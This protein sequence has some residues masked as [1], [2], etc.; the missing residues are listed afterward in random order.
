[1]RM[2]D[3]T[4]S[5]VITT[6]SGELMAREFI[7]PHNRQTYVEGREGSNF[8]LRLT[9]NTPN[10]V[11]AVPSVDGL[12]VLDGMA[13][14]RDSGGFVLEGRQTIDVP[15][16]KLD[17]GTAAQF[18]F[19][20]TKN[21]RDESYVAQIDQDTMNKGVIGLRVYSEKRH[22]PRYNDHSYGLSKGLG[23]NTRG[24]NS[25]THG[26]YGSSHNSIASLDSVASLNSV[27]SA[28]ACSTS[29]VTPETTLGT[30]FGSETNFATTQTTFERADLLAQLVIYYGDSR[31]LAKVGIDVSQPT[32]RGPIAF[33][34][35]AT[36]CAPPSGWKR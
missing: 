27:T 19:A 29:S 28:M 20:G 33:P 16:W 17:S 11:L 10:R 22:Y 32:V 6:P 26:I 24:M 34:A 21:G 14:G 3:I 15:G 30:G 35:D 25:A 18:F 2:N 12:S 5:I 9:N 13:A 36:G 4:M 23:S 8:I 7:S 1:M 31:Q